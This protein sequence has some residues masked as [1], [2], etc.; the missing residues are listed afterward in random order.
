MPASIALSNLTLSTPDGRPL[1]S[2]TSLNFGLER[3]GLVGRNGIGKTTL[4]KAISGDLTPLSGTITVNGTVAVARQS[5]LMVEDETVADLFGV[6]DAI[7]LLRR[8]EAGEAT[9]EE[10]AEADWTLD[11][12]VVAALGRVGLDARPGTRLAELSGGQSTRARLAAAIFC[13]PDFLLLDEP[14]NNLDRIGR[15]A[16]IRFLT[17]WHGGAIVI[18]HDRELLEHME[19]IVELTTLGITRYG[20]NWSAYRARRVIELEAARHDLAHAEK[21]VAEVKRKAQMATERKDRRDAAGARKGARGDLP[22]ILAGARKSKAQTSRGEEARLA[23]RQ[24]ADALEAAATARA[25]VEVLQ[26]LS[27]VLPSTK[28]AAGR[29][30]LKMD[31]V[32]AGYDASRPIIRDLSVSMVGPERVAVVGQNGSGKTTLLRLIAGE[33][34]PFRGTVSVMVDFALLDQRLSILDPDAT[35][36]DNFMRLNPGSNENAC[37]SA[38]ARFLFRAEASLQRASTL[39]GGQ[40]LRAGLACVLGVQQSP[41]LLILDEPTNHLDIDSLVA[42]EAG[43]RAFDGALLVVSHDEAFLKGI[44]VSRRLELIT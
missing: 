29:A 2:D 19:A 36:L 43:L 28:L 3:T 37:R 14:T 41:S 39:S 7:A 17:D 12:R 15:E 4:L 9:A 25:R 1:L 16:V 38:L 8:A 13:E 6:A 11:E 27:V 32:T 23:E 24:Q 34:K 33:V 20:G 42:V 31:G 21:T 44:G 35:I 30:V 22:R 10:L 5:A 26:E 18:S 40:I